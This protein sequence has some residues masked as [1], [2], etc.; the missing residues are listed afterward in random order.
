[1]IRC[2]IR[3]AA[4]TQ[5]YELFNICSQSTNLFYASSKPKFAVL[6]MVNTEICVLRLQSDIDRLEINWFVF[7]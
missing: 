7:N 1:M 3:R 2:V 6:V 5:F 4:Q